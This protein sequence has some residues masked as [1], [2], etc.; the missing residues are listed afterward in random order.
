MA[1]Y[2]GPRSK[3]ARRFSEPIFGFS[4]A[5][6]R[7]NY[8]PGEHGKKRKSQSEYKVQL[9]EKQKTKARYG[10]LE[11]QF[12]NLYKKASRQSGVTGETLLQMLELR[13]DNIIYRL[14][15]APTRRAARQLTSH[16]H[17]QVNNKTINIPSYT[18]KQGDIISLHHNAKKFETIQE[19]IKRP[20]KK[21]EWIIWDTATNQGKLLKVPARV[22]IPEKINEQ[23]I[24]ELYSKN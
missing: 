24:V 8:R 17:I 4:K 3:V 6:E 1:R 23:V 18:I 9:E 10:L 13:L 21:L 7:K 20:H 19:S 14:G 22:D 11:K 12:R 15:L 5:L 2:T 16:G